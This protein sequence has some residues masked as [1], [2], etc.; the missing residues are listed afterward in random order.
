MILLRN[1]FLISLLCFQE[2]FYTKGRPVF[3][4][5]NLLFRNRGRLLRIPALPWL[6]R[7]RADSSVRTGCPLYLWH[8]GCYLRSFFKMYSFFFRKAFQSLSEFPESLS[9]PHR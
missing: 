4:Q 6:S 8:Y 2:F 5:S 9:S 1:P 3:L 7:K